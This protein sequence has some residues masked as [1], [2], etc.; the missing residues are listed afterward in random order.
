MDK[1]GWRIFETGSGIASHAWSPRV[2]IAS[3]TPQKGN[4]RQAGRSGKKPTS[5]LPGQLAN[6]LHEIIEVLEKG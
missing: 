6:E 1:Q 2:Q 3:L 4:A 5:K